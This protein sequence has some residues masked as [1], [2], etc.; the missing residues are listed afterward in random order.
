MKEQKMLS[1]SVKISGLLTVHINLCMKIDV[2]RGKTN[3]SSSTK[4][5][6]A[7]FCM[8]VNWIKLTKSPCVMVGEQRKN[9]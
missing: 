4:A 1:V 3:S 2:L 6:I 9:L 5:K 8:S 7:A